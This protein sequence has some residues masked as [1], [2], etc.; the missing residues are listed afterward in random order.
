[1]KT[2]VLF[3]LLCVLL[4]TSPMVANENIYFPEGTKWVDRT[5]ERNPM[6]GEIIKSYGGI[7]TIEEDTLIEG[8]VYH[9]LI[10]AKDQLFAMLREDEKKIY[11]RYNDT[12]ML[13]YDFGVEVGDTIEY[14]YTAFG[15][16]WLPGPC[17]IYVTHIDT[18]TLLDGRNAKAIFFS[19]GRIGPDIEYVGSDRG[20]IAP[21]VSPSVPSLLGWSY[22]SCC[23]FNGEPIYEYKQGNCEELQNWEPWAVE[24]ISSDLPSATK[25]LRDAQILIIR[26]D[27]TYTLQGAELK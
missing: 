24:N 9:K 10:D 16:E 15:G 23:S 27:K 25:I 4:V 20:L 26:N 17:Q 7:Y 5:I 8:K 14:D 12:D 3:M 18:V 1:M 6:T 11:F 22:A 21:I 13:L 19:E 2:K